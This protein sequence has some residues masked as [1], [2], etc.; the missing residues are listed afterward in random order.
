MRSSH[1]IAASALA[2]ATVGGFAYF[3]VDTDGVTGMAG[4]KGGG[5]SGNGTVTPGYFQVATS[6]DVVRREIDSAKSGATPWLVGGAAATAVGALIRHPVANLVGIT[7][8]VALGIGAGRM[9]AASRANVDELE[10]PEHAAPGTPDH[11]RYY[12][13]DGEVSAVT[14]VYGRDQQREKRALIAMPQLPGTLAPPTMYVPDP[15]G[16]IAGRSPA[17]SGPPPYGP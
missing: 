6:R 10:L 15:F 17:P 4:S 16:A 1:V 13:R 12:L 11:M 2:A 5:R 14:P 7:G 8:A 9:I 3:T